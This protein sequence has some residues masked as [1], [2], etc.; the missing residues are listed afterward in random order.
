MSE[1]QDYENYEDYEPFEED[2]PASAIE[3]KQLSVAE[4]KLHYS[5]GELNHLTKGEMLLLLDNASNRDLQK[6]IL[7]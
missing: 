1:M 6:T 7:R 4:L 2:L 5:E 3:A